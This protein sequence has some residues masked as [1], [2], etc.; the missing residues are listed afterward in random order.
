MLAPLPFQVELTPHD[1]RWK[2][3]AEDE[4]LKIAVAIGPCL[5][6][7]HHIGSTSIPDIHAKPIIDLIPVVTSLTELDDRRPQ[8]EALGYEGWG[9]LGLPGRRYYT[10]SDVNTGQ[11]LVQLHCYAQGSPEITRHLAFRDYLRTHPDVA[12]AYEFEKLRCL[13]LHPEDSHAYGDCKGVWI[14]GVEAEA[15]TWFSSV[16]HA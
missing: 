12:R 1:P 15:L 3:K 16:N 6:R 14:E 11:R 9:E 2:S 5:V 7:V 13:A 8:I 4:S 10:K